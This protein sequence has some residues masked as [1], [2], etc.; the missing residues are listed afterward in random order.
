M[1][2]FSWCRL[3]YTATLYLFYDNKELKKG[4]TLHV[5]FRLSTDQMG[6]DMKQ[7]VIAQDR[8]I[9]LKLGPLRS[10]IL[11]YT[12]DFSQLCFPGIRCNLSEIFDHVQN[13]TTAC[14][15]LRYL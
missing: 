6:Y 4:L 14:D 15:S 2:S 10:T 11:H 7:R 3:L 8:G 9:C 12:N 1:N 13:V 5:K